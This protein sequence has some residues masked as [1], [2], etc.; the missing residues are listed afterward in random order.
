ME[1]IRFMGCEEFNKLVAG[2][3][4]V[5]HTDWH[6]RGACSR[7]K[8]FCFFDRSDPKELQA[9]YVQFAEQTIYEYAV[10]F[11]LGAAVATTVS[12]GRYR[13]PERDPIEKCTTV[14]EMLLSILEQHPTKMVREYSMEEYDRGLL[15]IKEAW[16]VEIAID[17]GEWAFSPVP[18][19]V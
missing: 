4:L 6:A 15:P 16:R 3:H 18:V 2:E 7:S 19:S 17:T 13:D 9:R 1:L 12:W 11:E 8:G 14:A 10:V 5:N